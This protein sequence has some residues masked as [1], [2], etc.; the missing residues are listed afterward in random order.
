MINKK[1]IEREGVFFAALVV[2]SIIIFGLH[3]YLFSH[4]F[5]DT[6]VTISLWSI[7]TFH[8]I[9]VFLVFTIANFVA[10]R[11]IGHVF[12]VFMGATL[13]KMVL[14]IVFLLPVLLKEVPN[15]T[16]DVLNF[17][18]PYF[19]FLAFEVVSVVLLMKRK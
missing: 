7:Y 13:L 1:F 8:F 9:T 18:I 15:A 11:N 5:E 4:F 14:A 16:A 17:F 12:V 10:E 6:I 19:V 3:S 2:F